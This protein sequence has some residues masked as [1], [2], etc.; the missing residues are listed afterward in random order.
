MYVKWLEGFKWDSEVQQK[1]IGSFLKWFRDKGLESSYGQAR[2][3]PMDL[4]QIQKD[5]ESAEW[6]AGV[7]GD[8]VSRLEK[9]MLHMQLEIE[10]LKARLGEDPDGL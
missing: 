1:G 5:H 7:I 10:E 9:K 8:Q 4:Y 3:E 6:F 2:L